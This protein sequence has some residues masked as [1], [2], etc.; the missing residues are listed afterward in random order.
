MASTLKER[1]STGDAEITNGFTEH[2]TAVDQGSKQSS[3]GVSLTKDPFIGARYAASSG[4]ELIC[5]NAEVLVSG[6]SRCS[7]ATGFQLTTELHAACEHSDADQA[8]MDAARGGSIDLSEHGN[9]AMQAM[10]RAGAT[11]RSLY[12]A[13]ADAEW[14]HSCSLE[15]D[16]VVDVGSPPQETLS[17]GNLRA[18]KAAYEGTLSPTSRD[19]IADFASQCEGKGR[20]RENEASV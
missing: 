10:R 7:C 19:A 13:V 18:S 12:F 8:V 2:A 11:E 14:R 16:A 5:V 17:D 3:A 6:D 4:G 9:N 15:R 1:G 20:R